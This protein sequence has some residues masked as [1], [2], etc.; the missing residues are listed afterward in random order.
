MMSPRP[1][2]PTPRHTPRDYVCF[3]LFRAVALVA[4]GHACTGTVRAATDGRICF[5]FP[6][7]R[8][9][10]DLLDRCLRSGDAPAIPFTP[11]TVAYRALREE[12]R[13][14]NAA[15]APVVGG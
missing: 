9:T 7:P 3:S 13:A 10:V 1:H 14:A 6:D 8:G 5:T 4:L 2:R 11:F 12:L 15:A